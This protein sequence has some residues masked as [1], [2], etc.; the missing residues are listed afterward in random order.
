[1]KT[2]KKTLQKKIEKQTKKDFFSNADFSK[3]VVVCNIIVIWGIVFKFFVTTNF[4]KNKTK[5]FG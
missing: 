3:C 4:K 5:K 2:I 1:M